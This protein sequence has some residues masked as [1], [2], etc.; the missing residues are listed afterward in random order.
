MTVSA[1]T[2]AFRVLHG[3]G[4]F[5]MPN[6]WDVGSA[7]MLAQLGFKAVATTSSGF[8][9]SMGRADNHVTLDQV[10]AHLRAMASS[11]DVPINAD[12]EGG[13]AD[14]PEAVGANVAA[15]AATGISGL[16]IED[17]TRNADAPL[18]DFSLA[19]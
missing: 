16:S 6:P 11:I 10:L 8:A 18:Y 7:R 19:V 1:K 3:A 15:A 9:W 17:S 12:F 14:A 13:F 4:C 5:V 2:S